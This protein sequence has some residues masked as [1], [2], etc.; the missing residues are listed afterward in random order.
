[1]DALLLRYVV[2]R[3]LDEVATRPEG[4]VPVTFT[5]FA[6]PGGAPGKPGKD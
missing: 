1:M 3:P 6:L 4:S 2:E 5:L